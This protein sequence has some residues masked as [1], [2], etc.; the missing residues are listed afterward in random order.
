MLL[1]CHMISQ[2]HVTKK[3][4]YG[5]AMG[6]SPKRLVTIMSTLVVMDIVVVEI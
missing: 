4:G 1:I 2:D 3:Y 6:K 5:N